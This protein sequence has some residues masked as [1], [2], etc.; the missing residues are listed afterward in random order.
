MNRKLNWRRERR[1]HLGKK[2]AYGGV[3]FDREGRVLLRKPEMNMTAINGPLPRGDRN[4]VKPRRRRL[5]MKFTKRLAFGLKN[6]RRHSGGV[7]RA[8]QR[9][10]L[11]HHDTRGSSGDPFD[12]ETEEIGG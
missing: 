1:E 3:V 6:D 7:S 11:F 10:S 5:W 2:V 9:E 8:G 4:R 12:D